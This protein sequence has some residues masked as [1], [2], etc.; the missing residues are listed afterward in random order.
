MSKEVPFIC[1]ELGTSNGL[2]SEK[3]VE[4][5][6]VA[7]KIALE[8]FK[9][10]KECKERC[11]DLKVLIKKANRSRRPKN[12]YRLKDRLE[13]EGIW[14]KLKYPLSRHISFNTIK[15][16]NKVSW[17]SGIIYNKNTIITSRHVVANDKNRAVITTNSGESIKIKNIIHNKTHDL[18]IVKTQTDIPDIK[19]SIKFTNRVSPDDALYNI[20]NGGPEESISIGPGDNGDNDFMPKTS[21]NTG[22]LSYLDEK[23]GVIGFNGFMY[24]G[25]SGGGVWL[26]DKLVGV[27]VAM[28][29]NKN[30]VQSKAISATEIEKLLSEAKRL[31]RIESLSGNDYP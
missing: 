23:D 6:R 21:I 7:Q 14:E 24:P 8:K 26:E 30:G 11:R 3:E 15:D 10:I 1:S 17:G 2:L 18:A 9:I 4:E 22:R 27:S 28:K 19:D 13:K 12:V 31:D 5:D 29:C 20:G 16:N 25:D